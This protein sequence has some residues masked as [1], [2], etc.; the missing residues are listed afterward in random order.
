MGVIYF[1]YLILSVFK[2]YINELY[3]KY[4]FLCEISQNFYSD[5]L[6]LFKFY[7]KGFLIIYEKKMIH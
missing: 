2:V 5:A 7:F 6:I 3:F 4:L 1:N